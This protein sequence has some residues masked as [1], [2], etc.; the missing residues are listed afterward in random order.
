MKQICVNL[1]DLRADTAIRLIEQRVE[2]RYL[3]MYVSRG[4]E[5]KSKRHSLLNLEVKHENK[6]NWASCW[7]KIALNFDNE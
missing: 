2:R 7:A 3:E 5:C 6:T 1:C 4:S